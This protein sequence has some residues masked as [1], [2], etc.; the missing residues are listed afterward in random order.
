MIFRKAPVRPVAA[1]GFTL[2]E[3]VIALSLL[4]LIM[5][6]LV[7]AMSTFGATAT[8]MDE[9]A[10]KD[11]NAWQIGMFLK[12]SLAQ[13]ARN[14]KQTLPDGT[15]TVFFR[16]GP[17]ELFWLGNMPARYGAGGMHFFWLSE[18][19]ITGQ[20]NLRYAPFVGIDIPPDP[21]AASTH[22]LVEDVT[23]FRAAY[24]SKPRDREERPEWTDAWGDPD[25]LPGRVR[26][27]ITV[28]GHPW[29]PLFF[30]L[31]EIDSAGGVRIV[32]GPVD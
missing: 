31:A 5:L 22:L 26:L 10:G 8:R 9:R 20:L 15:K 1:S 18:G 24:E 28:E 25:R 14:L 11:G 27:E 23:S 13:S 7:S 6:G 12:A 29:P 32:N 2:I 3:V 21:Q 17:R 4:S 16:G 19:D 30:T